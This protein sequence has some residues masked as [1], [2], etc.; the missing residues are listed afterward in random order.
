MYQSLHYIKH[1]KV[2]TEINFSHTA[3]FSILSLGKNFKKY[4]LILHWLHREFIEHKVF[5]NFNSF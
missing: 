5:S 1:S 2:K 4:F 3:Q